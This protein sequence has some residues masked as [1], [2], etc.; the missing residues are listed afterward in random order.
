MKIFSLSI[1]SKKSKDETVRLAAE[2]NL[3]SFG[4]FQ[5]STVQDIIMVIS[6]TIAERTNPGQRQ[7]I[8]EQR[9][10]SLFVIVFSFFGWEILIFFLILINCLYSLCRLC[11]CSFRHSSYRSYYY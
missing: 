8:E 6:K 10:N 4:F 1:Y 5:R 9:M 2:Y 11:L 7:R 3:T